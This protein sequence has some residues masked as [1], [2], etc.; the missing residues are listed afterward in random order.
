MEMCKKKTVAFDT[1]KNDQIFV[2]YGDC[3]EN[4]WKKKK[5][6]I[7]MCMIMQLFCENVYDHEIYIVCEFMY[8][9]I[10]NILAILYNIHAQSIRNISKVFS[11]HILY[12]IVDLYVFVVV[13]QWIIST[14]CQDE[15]RHHA[16]STHSDWYS[17]LAPGLC[18]D[19]HHLVA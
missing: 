10:C 13:L 11:V 15:R 19:S 3:W 2:V 12:D 14:S 17:V 7:I 5:I 4:V 9:N 18:T 16:E 1:Y 6:I 8:E